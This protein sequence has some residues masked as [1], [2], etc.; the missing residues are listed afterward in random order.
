MSQKDKKLVIVLVASILVTEKTEELEQIPYI[1]YP[2]TFKNW[3]KALLDLINK[4][5]AIS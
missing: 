3:T 5:N 1:W 4:V 2:V